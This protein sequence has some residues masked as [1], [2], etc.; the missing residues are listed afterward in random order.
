MAVCLATALASAALATNAFTLAWT[1][2]IEKLRWEESWIVHEGRLQLETVRVLGHGAGMEPPAGAVLRDGA[3][4]WHPH[5][6]H[7]R[8]HLVRSGYTA[9]YVWCVAG[10]PCRPLQDILP[11][12]GGVTEVWACDAGAD[13]APPSPAGLPAGLPPVLPAVLPTTGGG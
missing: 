1:H 5:S 6:V 8:L 3:W 12:D 4:Q 2:S 10:A 9:D 13:S 7:A 11:T